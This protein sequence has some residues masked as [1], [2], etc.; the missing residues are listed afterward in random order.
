M[1]GVHVNY[2]S[3]LAGPVLAISML[4]PAATAPSAVLNVPVAARV[5]SFV[6]PTP[7]GLVPIGI[8]YQPG[9]AASEAEA[10]DMERMLTG[11]F[12]LGRATLRT[13]RVAV[14]N[15]GQLA[16]TK[17][18]FVTT[19]LRAHQD[20][21]AAVAS[22]QSILTITADAGC[23]IAGKCIV[24]IS[25]ASKTQIIVNKAA[26]HRSGIRFG[27]AFLMLVKAV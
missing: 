12:T 5:I 10:N 27:S 22:A 26:A 15:L 9:N 18:A 19:G 17:A 3:I 8:V 4:W 2:L 21:V 23:V 14:S 24:G 16:G 20:E 6:Q 7:V 11:G 13:R 1:I 25:G